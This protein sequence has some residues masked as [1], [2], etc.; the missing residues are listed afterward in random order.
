MSDEE[1]DIVLS[2]LSD[3]DLVRPQNGIRKTIGKTRIQS[4]TL[5]HWKKRSFD[6]DDDDAMQG[7]EGGEHAG[8]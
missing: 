3:E 4:K 2:Q 5:V 7:V 8:A 1:D 6:E